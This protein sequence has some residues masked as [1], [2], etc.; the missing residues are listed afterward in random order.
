M[1]DAEDIFIIDQ[2]SRPQGGEFRLAGGP[3]HAGFFLYD[4]RPDD[5][6]ST[7]WELYRDRS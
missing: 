7:K 5:E 1:R 4:L 6:G 3:V 2:G